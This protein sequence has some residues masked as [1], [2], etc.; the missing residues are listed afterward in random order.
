[1][2]RSDAA[3]TSSDGAAQTTQP[4]RQ[5]SDGAEVDARD[6]DAGVDRE[7]MANVGLHAPLRVGQT[8]P[9]SA[10]SGLYGPD[11][12]ALQFYGADLGFTVKQADRLWILFGDSWVNPLVRKIDVNANQDADDALGFIDLT[13][14]PTGM[15]VEQ[16]VRDHPAPGGMFAWQSLEPRVEVVVNDAGIATPLRQVRD[17]VMLTSGAALTPSTGFVNP[18]PGERGGLF[19]IFFRNA[20]VECA[21]NTCHGGLTCDDGLGVCV[22][23]GGQRTDTSVPC[24]L[25]LPARAGCDQCQAVPGA[26][27]CVDTRSSVYDQSVPRG[28]TAAVA[29]THEVGNLVKGSERLF[30]TQAWA[31]QRFVVAA[32]S[33]VR[34]FS[35]ER[36]HGAGNDYRTAEGETPNPDHEGVFIFGRPQFGG[37]G[38]AGRDLQLYLAW[39]PMPSYAEDG[40]FEWQPRYY[41][42]QDD[43][44]RPQ[45]ASLEFDAEP[46]D[47]NVNEAGVQPEERIDVIGHFSVAYLPSHQRWIM[48]YGGG[49]QALYTELVYGDDTDLLDTSTIGP[50][51][52][53]FAEH[54]WGPWTDPETFLD[55]GDALTLTGQYAPGGILRSERCQTEGCVRGE[56]ILFE[57]GGVYA[58]NIIEPWLSPK[59]GGIDIY[60]HVSNWNP[61]EVVLMKTSLI[62]VQP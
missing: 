14:Y 21:S 29:M 1:M 18:D 36:R 62:E 27:L 32:A 40:H 53:R 51:H 20:P 2:S 26:G 39:V 31:T 11:R 6:D 24:V 58:P 45:F 35:A 60:W 8:E 49:A 61:Y 22:A 47:L 48:L 42:G 13:R 57:D 23:N 52:V 54:P 15:A 28:R 12:S 7:Q 55:P 56:P 10:I 16:A 17:G 9:L 25:G 4:A 33:S 59:P 30:A 5:S 43:Q 38:R 46:L 44:G 37:V 19:A 34:D 50:I 41:A 3:R